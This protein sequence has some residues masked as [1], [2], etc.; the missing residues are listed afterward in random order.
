M[1]AEKSCKPLVVIMLADSWLL[2]HVIHETRWNRQ[3]HGRSWRPQ[4]GAAGI[5]SRL[6]AGER[7]GVTLV[8]VWNSRPLRR[9]VSVPLCCTFSPVCVCLGPRLLGFSASCQKI[10]LAGFPPLGNQHRLSARWGQTVSSALEGG[11]VGQC[12]FSFRRPTCLCYTSF[13]LLGAH[14]LEGPLHLGV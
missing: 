9:A 14:T 11:S 2:Y 12:D 4:C 5:I 10:I 13:C 3:V 8:T 7:R 1:P 6:H